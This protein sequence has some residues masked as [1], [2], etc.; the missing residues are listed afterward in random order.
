VVLEL[1]LPPDCRSAAEQKAVVDAIAATIL[2]ECSGG[3]LKMNSL[4]D[5]SLEAVL[6][7]ADAASEMNV[8]GDYDTRDSDEED[9]HLLA[10]DVA[11]GDQGGSIHGANQ[12]GVDDHMSSRP[13]EKK[14]TGRKAGKP[15]SRK[16]LEGYFSGS[17]KDAAR[18]LGGKNIFYP[19]ISEN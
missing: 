11:Y 2:E 18:S 6:A 15:V 13:P 4:Q 9:E 10:V 7:D 1:F 12:H 16:V 14:K 8:H 17:L 3:S 5:Y 19:T